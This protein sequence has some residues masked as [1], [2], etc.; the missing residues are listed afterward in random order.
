MKLLIY[1]FYHLILF[2]QS[3]YCVL[4]LI[5]FNSKNYFI[6]NFTTKKYHSGENHNEWKHSNRRK[7]NIGH[8]MKNND[9]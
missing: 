5:F 6:M 1:R 3:L 4:G 2:F 7:K 8:N 9:K